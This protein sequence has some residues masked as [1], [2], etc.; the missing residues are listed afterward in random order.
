M[1]MLELKNVYQSYHKHKL[2]LRGITLTI[3]QGQ[4]VSIIG[5][6]GAGKTTLLRLFNHM[7][8]PVS[9]E[10]WVGGLRFDTLNGQKRR[11]VQHRVGMVFQDFCLVEE[12]T[13]LQNVLNGCLS[14]MPI[15]R[16]VSGHF[17]ARVQEQARAA[18]QQ[19]G[20]AEQEHALAASLSGGQKQR[21]AIARALLQKAEVLLADE[22]VA[23]LDPMT[24]QQIL[25]LLRKLQRQEGLTVVMNSHNVEQAK[26][27]SDRIIGLREG[28]IYYDA[29][30][31]QWTG[32]DFVQLYGRGIS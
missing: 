8:C 3:K 21:V 29:A 1:D 13:C 27:F 5:P 11:Q 20:L 22:P 12:S 18:L 6:S 24:A 25:V 2:I 32:Q 26:K 4:F 30:P 9:G 23:S 7:A 15:W 19:V 14:D 31:E 28:K 17:P 10:V 16:V